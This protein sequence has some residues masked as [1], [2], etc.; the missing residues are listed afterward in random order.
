[1]NLLLIGP[2][3][4]GKGTQG[5]R[6]ATHFG[7][8]H[9]ATGEVLRAE[10]AAGTDLGKRVAVLMERGDLVPDDVI[11]DLMLPRILAAARSNGYLLDGFPRT[12]EQAE[13]IHVVAAEDEVPPDAVVYLDVAEDEL[14]RRM[15]KRAEIEGRA[16]D[17]LETVAN[18]L[19]VFDDVTK[20]L[21]EYYRVRDLLYIVDAAQSEDEVTEAILA[22]L[23]QDRLPS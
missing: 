4:S 5:D 15:L 16:D 18:R 12:V 3:G 14:V 8:E 23:P 6:L 1:M 22:A 21:V 17:N 9:I 13:R 7:L 19:R 20:P 11:V 2:P 10:V